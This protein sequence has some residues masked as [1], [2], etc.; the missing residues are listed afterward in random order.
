[1][2]R[3]VRWHPQSVCQEKLASVNAA[4][5]RLRRWH[6]DCAAEMRKERDLADVAAT[7]KAWL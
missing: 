5:H 3:N 1:M 2:R 4:A 7:A 6:G